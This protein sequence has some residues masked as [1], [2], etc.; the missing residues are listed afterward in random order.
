MP[1]LLSVNNYYYRRD[2]S[3]AVYFDHN[4]LLEESGWSVVP[5]SMQHPKN[6]ESEYASYFVTEIEYGNSYNLI[7]KLVRVP[8]IIYSVEA[9]R[10]LEALIAAT[11][12]DLCHC[13][14]IYHHISPSILTS[15]AE[16]NI[17]VVMTLHDFKLLCPA[18]H[19]HDGKNVCE[20]CKG[21]RL[22]NVVVRKCVKNSTALSAVVMLESAIHR[23]LGSYT[24]YIDKF[25][26]PSRF[27][28][29]KFVEWGWDRDR[30]IHIPNSIDLR[31]YQP[32]FTSG[33]YVLYFGRLSVE[34]GLHTLIQ[35]AHEAGI[36]LVIAGEGPQRQLLQ[37][38]VDGLNA[39]VRFL[40]HLNEEPLKKAIEQ[41][42]FTVLP[43]ECYENASISIL[44]SMALGKPVLGAN[45]G[46]IPEVINT[47]GYRPF[48]ALFESGSVS[49]LTKALLTLWTKSDAEL[50][51]MGQEAR[52]F[53]ENEMSSKLYQERIESLYADIL[54]SR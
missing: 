33:S 2:G 18:Y 19:M 37:S 48:G 7:E 15:L 5:F 13:H 45:L 4:R 25:I 52:S 40:G 16:V 41:S 42:R 28:I 17:P 30:F 23:L 1:K 24:G 43:S 10:K 20:A 11:R 27:Y 8:K 35:A 6:F 26:S 54:R 49:S 31:N 32:S 38:L 44:E 21:G 36:P 34:K 46:G 12:P 53:V 22:H 39:D 9:K 14:S 47:P 51:A 3:E 29:D 50:H